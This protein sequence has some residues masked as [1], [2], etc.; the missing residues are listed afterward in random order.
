[1]A[2]HC[3]ELYHD[4]HMST[5][6]RILIT[7]VFVGIFG[8]LGYYVFEKTM[9]YDGHEEHIKRLW[10]LIKLEKKLAKGK[11]LNE[12]EMKDKVEAQKDAE[13]EFG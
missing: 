3:D 5:F 10:I 13:K 4:W 1:M 2:D 7:M 11:E 9:V 6:S 8:Y 12:E